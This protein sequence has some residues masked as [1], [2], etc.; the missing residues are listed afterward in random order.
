MT[1]TAARA[2]AP[3]RRAA[4]GQNGPVARRDERRE[5]FSSLATA[6]KENDLPSFMCRPCLV[7]LGQRPPD[8][9]IGRAFLRRR[10]AIARMPSEG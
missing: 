8:A 10:R 3:S 1:S 6:L 4:D 7:L 9:R 2:F 5:S